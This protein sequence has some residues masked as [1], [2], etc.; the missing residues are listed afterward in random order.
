MHFCVPPLES[1]CSFICFVCLCIFVSPPFFFFAEPTFAQSTQHRKYQLERILEDIDEDHAATLMDQG[2]VVYLEL[3]F[4]N[5]RAN[6]VREWEKE[7]GLTTA[8]G[9][10]CTRGGIK[11]CLSNQVTILVIFVECARMNVRTLTWCVRVCVCACVL[12]MFDASLLSCCL[13]ERP[14]PAYMEIR[15]LRRSGRHY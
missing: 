8:D 11:V 6:E 2:P 5:K 3:Q 15:L 4:V 13:S 14:I 9:Q 7:M 10:L 12:W 1:L